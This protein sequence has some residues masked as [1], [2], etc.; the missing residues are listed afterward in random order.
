MIGNGSGALF[1]QSLD[2]LAEAADDEFEARRA[3][4]KSGRITDQAYARAIDVLT[5]RADQLQRMMRE[6][7]E[8]KA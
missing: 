1:R 5:K 3:L 7:M 8:A 6:W 2:V 4:W